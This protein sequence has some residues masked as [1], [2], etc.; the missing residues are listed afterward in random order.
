VP[1]E[2]GKE[3][4]QRAQHQGQGKRVVQ[5]QHEGVALE[6]RGQTRRTGRQTR[7]RGAGGG[8]GVYG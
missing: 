3:T 6:A 4:Q 8:M 7:G 1:D 2:E 5:A